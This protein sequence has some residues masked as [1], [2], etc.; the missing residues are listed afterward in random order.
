[1]AHSSLMH[2]KIKSNNLPKYFLALM[3]FL[4]SVIFFNNEDFYL[5]SAL[6]FSVPL[7]SFINHMFRPFQSCV[8]F[9]PLISPFIAFKFYTD[10]SEVVLLNGVEEELFCIY[11]TYSGNK[12]QLVNG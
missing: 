12:Q 3:F 4:Y 11:C 9:S 8:P 10:Q 1:M 5:S 2:M 7:I 6:F